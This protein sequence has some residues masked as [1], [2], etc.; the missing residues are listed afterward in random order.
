MAFAIF[1]G[2]PAAP[3]I[4]AADLAQTLL[5]GVPLLPTFALAA[6]VWECDGVCKTVI[7]TDSVPAISPS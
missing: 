7:V 5:P 2:E 1:T 3:Y 4:A 6:G